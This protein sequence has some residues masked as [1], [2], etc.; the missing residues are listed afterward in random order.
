MSNFEFS[1]RSCGS[2]DP[3]NLVS[4]LVSLRRQ[5]L[6]IAKIEKLKNDKQPHKVKSLKQIFNV[7]EATGTS[8][9]VS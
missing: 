7:R 9:C 4:V 3:D 5:G 2:G 6:Q 1:P 8:I